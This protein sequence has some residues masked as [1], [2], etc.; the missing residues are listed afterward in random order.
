[1]S[2]VPHKCPDCGTWWAW[3]STHNCPPMPFT[4]STTLAATT[5]PVTVTQ[6]PHCGGRIDPEEKS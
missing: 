2:A 3:P 1:M 6:C 5:G 4:T